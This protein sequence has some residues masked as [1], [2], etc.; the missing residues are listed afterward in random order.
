MQKRELVGNNENKCKPEF[1]MAFLL[2]PHI[3]SL[4]LIYVKQ[5]IFYYFSYGASHTYLSGLAYIA[6]EPLV[7]YYIS[8]PLSG[9]NKV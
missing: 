1:F 6:Q 9:K 3:R 2:E 8:T 5:K 7:N 4:W